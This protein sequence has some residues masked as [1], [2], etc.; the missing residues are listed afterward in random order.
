MS[1]FTLL[2]IIF[3]SRT[4][5]SGH[6]FVS[7]GRSITSANKKITFLEKNENFGNSRLEGPVFGHF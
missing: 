6:Q 1:I 4:E 7:D 3:F 5:K 2:E